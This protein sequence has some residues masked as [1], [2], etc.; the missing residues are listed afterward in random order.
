MALYRRTQL[1]LLCYARDTSLY[2]LLLGPGRHSLV[3]ERLS[4]SCTVRHPHTQHTKQQQHGASKS[5]NSLFAVA[6]SRTPE[7]AS[8][9]FSL[10]QRSVFIFIPVSV[11]FSFARVE[12]MR[13]RWRI[14]RIKISRVRWQQTKKKVSKQYINTNFFEFLFSR[15]AFN[16]FSLENKT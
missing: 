9:F 11:W 10:L 8:K 2:L 15:W 16:I 4:S 14:F 1:R 3:Q 13:K 12:E 5:P 7:S 6:R